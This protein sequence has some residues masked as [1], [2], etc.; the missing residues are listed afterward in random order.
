[1]S[2]GPNAM[3]IQAHLREL[4]S[5]LAAA[6][7]TIRTIESIREKLRDHQRAQPESLDQPRE[8]GRYF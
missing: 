7:E 1:M 5:L 4:D 6:A 8:Q 2:D 3:E